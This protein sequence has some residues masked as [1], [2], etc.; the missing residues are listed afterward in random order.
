MH[1]ISNLIPMSVVCGFATLCIFSAEKYLSGKKR[2]LVKSLGGAMFVIGVI[3]FA[4]LPDLILVTLGLSSAACFYL[5]E[6]PLNNFNRVRNILAALGIILLIWA[7][8]RFGSDI[9]F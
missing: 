6:G 2:S 4:C 5:A 8:L 3:V 9:A 1:D 7:L